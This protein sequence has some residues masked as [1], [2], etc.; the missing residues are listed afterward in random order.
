MRNVST[1]RSAALLG[2]VLTCLW[3]AACGGAD[4]SPAP[5][6]PLESAAERGAAA[7]S[8]SSSSS[9]VASELAVPK[10]LKGPKPPHANTM[11]QVYVDPANPIASDDNS[12]AFE[13]PLRT[14][15]AAMAQLKA[16][17]DVVIGAGVYRETV[18]LPAIPPSGYQT[19][20]RAAVRGTVTVK[21]SDEVR[22]WKQVS[23][24]TWSISWVG[25]EPEQVFRAGALLQQVGGTVFGGYP[26][27]PANPLIGVQAPS[28]IWPGR[29]NG[30][31]SSLTPDS[32]TYDAANRLLYVRLSSPLASN[33]ALE[34]STRTYVL[35]GREVTGVVVAGIDFLHSNTSLTQRHG[36]VYLQGSANTIRN[37]T[38]R[39]MDAFCVMLSGDESR[40]LN[41]AIEYCGQAG[42]NAGGARLTVAGNTVGHNNTRGFNKSWEAGGMKFTGSPALVDSSVSRNLAVFNNGD[43]IWF[44]STPERI[45]IER[46]TAAYNSGHGIHYEASVGGTIVG[47][48][49]YG[50]G[51]RGIYLLESSNTK[52]ASNITFAN[53]LQGIAVLDG[54]RSATNPRLL[55]YGN[56][57]IGNTAAWNDARGNRIQFM[58]PGLQFANTSDFN[59]VHATD[60]TPRYAQGDVSGANPYR[61]GLP[62]WRPYAG[63]DSS[64]QE[65]FGPMPES[66]VASLNERRVLVL[67]NLP[68]LLQM[69]GVPRP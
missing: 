14:L 45:Q 37:S 18:Q 59:R 63:Q 11:R 44:D 1:R 10:P 9:P 7:L 22:G 34:V 19:V 33:E 8:A 35:Y 48:M 67:A 61:Q 43:G 54:T 47:N 58:L 46:N 64:S 52:V 49:T 21:G 55:P 6:E 65:S 57:V 39:F 32:F 4:P 12:G 28:G 2:I 15:S 29:V 23:S 27:N 5:I 36:A 31:K 3:L 42:V 40:L 24:D 13:A 68:P 38:I 62:A 25:N 69:A 41:S 30:D 16:G 17:D 66:L 60:V 53:A 50:N 56:S 20:I 51:H 26:T